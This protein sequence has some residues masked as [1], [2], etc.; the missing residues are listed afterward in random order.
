MALFLLD[1]TPTGRLG[2]VLTD[3][4]NYAKIQM[5]FLRL[6]ILVEFSSKGAWVWFAS[7]EL[8]VDP[9]L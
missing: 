9:S 7:V 8:F 3:L 1:A 6:K 2:S 5:L 4:G